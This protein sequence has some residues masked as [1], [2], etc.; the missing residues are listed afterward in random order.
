MMYG[1]FEDAAF[2]GAPNGRLKPTESRL[3]PR[4]AAPHRLGVL[5]VT[6]AGVL[7]GGAFGQ[8]SDPRG[9]YLDSTGNGPAA[10]RFNVQLEHE[11][12]RTLVPATHTFESGDRMKFQFELNR[13]SYVYILLRS[14]STDPARFDRYAGSRGIEIVRDEDERTTTT[15]SG[16]TKTT[17]TTKTT[18]TATGTAPFQLLFPTHQAGGDNLVPAHVS[19]AF[20]SAD[21]KYFRMDRKPGMEKLLVVVSPTPID[22]SPYFDMANGKLRPNAEV[23]VQLTKSLMEY[24]GNANVSSSRGIEIE[25]Y[26][27]ASKAAKPM[28][29]PVDLRHVAGK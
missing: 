18:T 4:M 27:A 22:F 12:N 9:M 10:I 21:D 25:S 3:Q 28:L 29:V 24:S 16:T 5:V 14:V 1:K 7:V 20:P 11:G 2:A 17:S 6:V 19:K 15:G 13:Q 23:S 26:A 8:T